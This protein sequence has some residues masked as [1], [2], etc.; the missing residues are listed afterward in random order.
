MMRERAR[1]IQ[2]I[3][4]SGRILHALSL[5]SEPMML[6]QLAQSAGLV[7]AQCHAYLTSMRHVGL[8]QQDPLSGLYRVGSFTRQLGNAWLKSDPLAAE[9]IRVLTD[10][11]DKADV[12]SLLVVWGIAG[13]TIVHV[14]AGRIQTALNIRQGTLFSVTG[15][16][17]GRAF[18]AFGTAPDLQ[19]RIATELGQSRRSDALGEVMTRENFE[20]QVDIARERGYA[21]TEGA[22]IPGI[23][24]VSTPVFGE[25]GQLCFVLTIIGPT[26]CLPVGADTPA[27]RALLEATRQLNGASDEP[28]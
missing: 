13:P 16:A 22:P 9:A 8:V 10:I 25:N 1:G 28:A 5:A 27:V 24:A 4:V 23:N 11:S 14:N 2:S 12:M 21:T 18:A 15:T 19:D 7:P 17:T 3:E 26:S 20:R 6:K